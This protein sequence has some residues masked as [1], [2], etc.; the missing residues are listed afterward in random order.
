MNDDQARYL[1][2]QFNKYASWGTKQIGV[3]KSLAPLSLALFA[4]GWSVA[5]FGRTTSNMGDVV[6][7]SAILV[8]VVF[9]VA[10]IYREEWRIADERSRNREFLIALERHRATFKSLPEITLQDIV[11]DKFTAESLKR[12]PKD[13]EPKVSPRKT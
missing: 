4:L 11:G 5:T 6:M 3:M 8:A 2:D 13:N 10:Y 9:M 7:L 12:F 1:I